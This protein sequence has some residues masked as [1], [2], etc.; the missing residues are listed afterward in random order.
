MFRL[1]T[2]KLTK[3]R[4]LMPPGCFSL[5]VEV[6]PVHF[7]KTHF[8]Y[9]HSHWKTVWKVQHHFL[10]VQKWKKSKPSS[11]NK[12]QFYLILGSVNKVS[13]GDLSSGR[14]FDNGCTCFDSCQG[15][16][17]DLRGRKTECKCSVSTQTHSIFSS[18]NFQE[19]I[20]KLNLKSSSQVC[21]RKLHMIRLPKYRFTWLLRFYFRHLDSC[22]NWSSSGHWYRSA[23]SSAA[24]RQR[25]PKLSSWSRN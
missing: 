3:D 6:I 11:M 25:R 24:F 18:S 1:L 22:R 16:V 17:N 15:V 23:N 12:K 2:K 9:F 10:S 19:Q 8:Y 14:A 7:A 4:S 20:S 21:S 13:L 5:Y